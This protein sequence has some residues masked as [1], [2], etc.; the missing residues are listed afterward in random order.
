MDKTHLKDHIS[1]EDTIG[2]GYY[3]LPSEVCKNFIITAGVSGLH[4]S[5]AVMK[6]MYKINRSK[7]K[8][9][10][11][12]PAFRSIDKEIISYYAGELAESLVYAADKGKGVEIAFG[13]PKILVIS[14][15]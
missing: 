4:K 15:N 11:I 13:Y 14:V 1:L 8:L 10:D 9:A 6:I 7:K 5:K 12:I 3:Y 2:Y